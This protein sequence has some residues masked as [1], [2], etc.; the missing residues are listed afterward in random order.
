MCAC[1]HSHGQT[2]R[3]SGLLILSFRQTNEGTNA[4]PADLETLYQ[5]GT[6]PAPPFESIID[7]SFLLRIGVVLEDWVASRVDGAFLAIG[8]IFINKR[9]HR[10][11]ARQSTIWT[12]GSSLIQTFC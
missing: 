7:G 10:V 4:T 11:S 9:R 1:L 5:L 8:S 3:F 12:K 2:V 6:T